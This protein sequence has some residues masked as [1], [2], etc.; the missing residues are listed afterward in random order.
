MKKSVHNFALTAGFIVVASVF[1]TQTQAADPT[2]SLINDVIT[3][4]GGSTASTAGATSVVSPDLSEVYLL[5][6][7][8]VTGG[9]A[10]EAIGASNFGS[11]SKYFFG[12]ASN[13]SSDIRISGGTGEKSFGIDEFSK[14]GTGTA[15]NYGKFTVYGGTGSGSVGI[16]KFAFDSFEDVSGMT[17]QGG[18]GQDSYGI[19]FLNTSDSLVLNNT[20]I[21]GGTGQRSD[22][23][24]YTTGGHGVAF[25]SALGE[26]MTVSG[27]TVRG[28]GDTTILTGS[29]GI[30]QIRATKIIGGTNS[31]M[32][33]ITI[34]AGLGMN[35]TGIVT[36]M[37]LDST[38]YHAG[39]AKA[40]SLGSSGKGIVIRGG[41]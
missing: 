41:T 15:F 35:S 37:Q 13:A 34:E 40:V 28:G 1:G 26:G 6:T 8:R 18:S 32:P 16:N 12:S 39:F 17:I 24:G 23:V 5:N 33:D 4:S 21:I 3:I 19:Q 7:V 10:T 36:F 31:N 25:L 38:N 11:A 14:E 30:Y 9:S 20:T 2:T 22:R 27:V 29:P